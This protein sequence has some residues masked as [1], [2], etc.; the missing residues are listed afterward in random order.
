MSPRPLLTSLAFLSSL[1]PGVLARSE[2]EGKLSTSWQFSEGDYERARDCLYAIEAQI[3]RT[4]GFQ[5]HVALPHPLCINYLQTLDAFQT[6]SEEGSAVAKRA[7]EHLN[8][9]L[10]SPQLVYLT[11][12]PHA[13]AVSAIYLAAREVEVKLPGVEWWEVFDVDREELGFLVVAL[14][15]I[16]GFAVQEREKWGSSKV[17][18]TVAELREEV[19]R[20]EAE[21]EA[22]ANV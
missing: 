15:S 20:R 4:L 13:L 22:E 7:F 19:E 2:V 14:R 17:P 16:E 3:L 9:A 1:A 18:M 10:L 12:Q 5:T 8:G 21:A 6:S 11:H